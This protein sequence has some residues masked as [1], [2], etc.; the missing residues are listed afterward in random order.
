[1][2]NFFN[3]GVAVNL[4]D[5][6]MLNQKKRNPSIH[7]IVESRVP[8]IVNWWLAGWSCDPRTSVWLHLGFY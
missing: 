5:F 3:A 8:L 6:Q 7:F 1:M 4:V 2:Q